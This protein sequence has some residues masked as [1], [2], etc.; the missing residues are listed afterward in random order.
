MEEMLV[1]PLLR[2]RDKRLDD[3]VL[4]AL[5]EHHVA[6]ATLAELDKMKVSDERYEAKMTVLREAIEHHI[7]EEE[8]N[9]LPRLEKMLEPEEAE[10]L[11]AEMV[12]GKMAAPDHPHP[13]APDTPPGNVIT[14]ALAKI[15]DTGKDVVRKVTSPAKAQGHRRQVRRGRAEAKKAMKNLRGKKRAA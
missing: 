3:D 9:L 14:G 8:E 10:A 15:L 11:A 1:Y 7:E 13:M 5:E 2:M 6:K 12:A 4:E